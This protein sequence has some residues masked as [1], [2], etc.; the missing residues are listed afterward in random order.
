MLSASQSQHPLLSIFFALDHWLSAGIISHIIQF[1]TEGWCRFCLITFTVY[2][3]QIFLARMWDSCSWYFSHGLKPCPFS[4]AVK[5]KF[6]TDKLCGTECF[7]TIRRK[8]EYANISYCNLFPCI[9][10]RVISAD[11]L[12]AESEWEWVTMVTGHSVSL[13]L[14]NFL[15]I[16]CS[17]CSIVPK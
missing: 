12:T 5:N 10:L 14:W 4:H 1:L 6:K 13:S 3:K 7:K 15:R 17:W 9:L 2:F 16:C 11:L 8:S